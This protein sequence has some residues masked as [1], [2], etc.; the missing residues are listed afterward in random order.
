MRLERLE[1]VCYM[2]PDVPPLSGEA[3][4]IQLRNI[5]S[6]TVFL[7]R[8]L[9]TLFKQ[10]VLLCLNRN[11][12]RFRAGWLYE[13]LPAATVVQ[14]FVN[15]GTLLK[16]LPKWLL[17]WLYGSRK[18]QGSLCID[19]QLVFQYFHLDLWCSAICW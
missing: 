5:S 2:C 12:L 1:H 10:T 16:L 19:F 4:L 14:Y 15:K 8:S 6:I 18:N 3:E 13:G 9:K 11:L 17:A 7:S